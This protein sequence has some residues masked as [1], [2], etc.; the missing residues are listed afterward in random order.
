MKRRIFRACAVL[1]VLALL[2]GTAAD[3]E[4]KSRVRYAGVSIQNEE[5]VAS[6]LRDAIKRKVSK[7]TVTFASYGRNAGDIETLAGALMDAAFAE[8]GDPTAGDYLRYQT[9]GYTAEYQRSPDGVKAKHTLTI[10]PSYYTTVEEEAAVDAEVVR[11][12]ES[13]DFDAETSD[14]EKVRAIYDYI[15]STVSYDR[16]HEGNQNHHKK[17]TAYAALVRHSAVCQGYAVATYRL[18][19]EAGLPV[20]VVVG[21]AKNPETGESEYHAW[22]RV[23]VDGEWLNFDPTWGSTTGSNAYF[24]RTDEEF[25]DHWEKEESLR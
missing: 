13:F 4:A 1:T 23:K 15:T 19:A 8:V 18:C 10:Q 6:Q 20:R 3:A 17:A 2:L 16:V 14:E 22:N 25:Q 21:D 11:I 24:L 9:G 5:A 7:I 12:L